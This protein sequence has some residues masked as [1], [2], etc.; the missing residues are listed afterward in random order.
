MVII[1]CQC[2]DQGKLE[3]AVSEIVDVYV[4]VECK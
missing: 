1:D 2:E 3:V 4:G